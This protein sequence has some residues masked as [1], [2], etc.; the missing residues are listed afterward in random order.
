[1]EPG[2]TQELELGGKIYPTVQIGGQVWMAENLSLLVKNSWFYED[3][4]RY[5]EQFGRLYTWQA[6]MDACPEGWRMPTRDD[7]NLMIETLGGEEEAF[8]KL[9]NKSNFNALYG[10]YRSID[11][12]FMSINRVADFWSSTQAGEANA[13]LFYLIYKKNKV[14]SIIDD[15]RCGFSVRYIKD[16]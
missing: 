11:G 5:G 10:G 4:A 2:K 14:Y 15:K 16:L 3:N 13:W 8:D 6:A 7:W 1:M 9:L 12:I